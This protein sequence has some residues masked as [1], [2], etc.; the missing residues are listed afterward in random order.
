MGHFRVLR[1]DR[2]L[3]QR[4]VAEQSGVSLSTV[5][6]ADGERAP[7]SFGNIKAFAKFFEVPPASL[8]YLAELHNKDVNPVR[9]R[10]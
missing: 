3:T 5:I 8:A 1:R 7:I 2:L 6:R 4:E 10:S 9:P